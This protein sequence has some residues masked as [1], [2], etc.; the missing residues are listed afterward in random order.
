[1]SQHILDTCTVNES[2]PATYVAQYN[3]YS[4]FPQGIMELQSEL[5]HPANQDLAMHIAAKH[6]DE[7]PSL[8]ELLAEILAYYNIPIDAV[9]PLPELA[10]EVAI[11]L[12]NARS[13]I[14]YVPSNML[15]L[16]GSMI[17]KGE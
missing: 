4:L 11:L 6:N 15:K 9:V 1:M 13:R 3:G 16:Y 7:L 17:D 10:R 12:F 2:I 14:Q 5:M 8:D